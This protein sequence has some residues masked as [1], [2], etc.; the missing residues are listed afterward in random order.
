MS[1]PF[2]QKEDPELPDSYGIKVWYLGDRDP[3]EIDVASHIIIDKV[4]KRDYNHETKKVDF[5]YIGTLPTPYIEYHS[6]DDKTGMIPLNSVKHIEF[7]TRF[8]KIR[9]ISE[10]N[11]KADR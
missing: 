3:V 5:S 6:K 8:S 10:K 7:D 11:R 4:Y 1:K 9:E 2:I